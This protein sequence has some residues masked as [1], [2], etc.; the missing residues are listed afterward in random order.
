M[1]DDSIMEEKISFLEELMELDEGVLK[2]DTELKE[3]EEWDS[4]TKLSLMAECKKKY[5]LSLTA[6][7]IRELKTVKDICDLL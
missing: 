5:D 7:Q 3:I 4:L 1:E 2:L 6:A